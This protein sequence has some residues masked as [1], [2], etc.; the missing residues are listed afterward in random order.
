MYSIQPV[1]TPEFTDI[2]WRK[3]YGLLRELKRK[4]K[5]YCAD[6]SPGE[7]RKRL[8]KSLSAEPHYYHSCVFE[9]TAVVGWIN[10]HVRNQGTQDQLV[11]AH[12]DVAPEMIPN[13]LAGT[14]ARWVLGYLEEYAAPE[15]YLPVWRTGLMAMAESWYGEFI[16]CC[17]NN[18]LHRADANRD[19]IA[20][21]LRDL[22]AANPGLRLVFTDDIDDDLFEPYVALFQ[23]GLYDMPEEVESGMSR[24]LDPDELKRTIRAERE[25]GV[26]MHQALILDSHNRLVGVSD[27]LVNRKNPGEIHQLMT[28]VERSRRGSGLAKWLK[29]A[30]FDYLEREVEGF[31]SLNT[32]MRAINEPIQAINKKMGFVVERTGREYKIPRA[33]IEAFLEKGPAQTPGE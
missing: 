26:I 14:L 18:V 4:H 31:E 15:F 33:G 20:K 23:Q 17:D 21:W 6:R 13:R 12:L 16:A 29:A 8:L 2:H 5:S 1:D 22:P 9:G 19:L 27:V 24:K 30:M 28:A 25:T 3:L 7:F 32:W 10:L 11:Y